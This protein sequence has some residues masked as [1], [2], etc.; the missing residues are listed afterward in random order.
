[1]TADQATRFDPGKHIL[2]IEAKG[3]RTIEREVELAE[4]GGV[5]KLNLRLEKEGQQG[6]TEPPPPPP[7]KVPEGRTLF[8]PAMVSFGVGAASLAAGAFTGAMSFSRADVLKNQCSSN[9]RCPPSARATIDEGQLLGN[10]STA[11]FIVGGAAVGAGVVLLIVGKPKSPATGMLR[12]TIP[13]VAP[14]ML[15]L[16]GTF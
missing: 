16:R 15:G 10:I 14:G 11:T 6:V 4:R 3:Y 5:I 8:V 1:L 13:W 7:P 12:Q 9:G 2:R